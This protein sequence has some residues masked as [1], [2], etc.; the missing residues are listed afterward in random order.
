MPASLSDGYTD[1]NSLLREIKVRFFVVGAVLPR[2][3]HATSLVYG[4]PASTHRFRVHDLARHSYGSAEYA[5]QR[6][7]ETEK[8][9]NDLHIVF[10]ACSRE[11]AHE[12]VKVNDW[13]IFMEVHRLMGSSSFIFKQV[14]IRVLDISGKTYDLGHRNPSRTQDL[15]NL[16]HKFKQEILFP[17]IEAMRECYFTEDVAEA[18]KVSVDL[19]QAWSSVFGL[20]EELN[21]DAQTTRSRLE[22][23]YS[24]VQRLRAE[25]PKDDGTQPCVIAALPDKMQVVLSAI[26]QGSAPLSR[27]AKLYL[28]LE[29]T[30]TERTSYTSLKRLILSIYQSRK[31]D[32]NTAPA[33]KRRKIILENTHD[34]TLTDE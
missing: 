19:M 6:H 22:R 29:L 30:E 28:N 26:K 2:T 7:W 9:K 32:N 33:T 8:A 1:F 23:A 34:E 3:K 17:M 15:R 31:R 25:K 14:P 12:F 16:Q 10:D 4:F 5:F 18:H 21:R 24:A 11:A 27:R 13:P 20:A